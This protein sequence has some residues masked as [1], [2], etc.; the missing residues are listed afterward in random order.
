MDIKFKILK[1][2]PSSYRSACE[3]YVSQYQQVASQLRGLIFRSMCP[4]LIKSSFVS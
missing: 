3:S 2:L 1:L 4:Q